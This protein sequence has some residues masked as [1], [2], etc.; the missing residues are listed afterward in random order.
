MAAG[1]TYTPIATNTLGSATASV[2]FS[3]ISGS[4]T[5]LVL[6]IQCGVS[7]TNYLQIQLN[8]D[9]TMTNY[10]ATWM[11]G[12]GSSAST[13]RYSGATGGYNLGGATTNTTLENMSIV[14]F[15]NYSNSTTYKTW[16][17]RND[18]ASRSAHT[19]VGLWRNTAAITS[20]LIKPYNGAYNL[21]SGSTFTLYGIAAA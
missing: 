1:S 13:G 8:S 9:T 21:A 12:D 7:T 15:Q 14:H 11:E 3:A 6:V 19:A 5:D 17:V 2:T 16:V 20:I 4:Y 10:S 18:R